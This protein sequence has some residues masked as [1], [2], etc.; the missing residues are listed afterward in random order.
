VT[1][2]LAVAGGTVGAATSGAIGA[3]TGLA[4]GLW[5]GGIQWW[6]QLGLAVTEEEQRR[7]TA[8]APVPPAADPATARP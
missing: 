3:A 7:A 4:L 2:V 6:H 1:G 5:I 8:D